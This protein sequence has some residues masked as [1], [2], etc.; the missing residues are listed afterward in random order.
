MASCRNRTEAELVAEVGMKLDEALA[1]AGE[2][3]GEDVAVSLTLGPFGP[4]CEIFR[5]IRRG[6]HDRLTLGVARTWLLAFDAARRST[7][8][9]R[10]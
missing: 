4:Q 1:R 7:R 2:A 3:F 8:S 10:S 9:R 6:R 5:P